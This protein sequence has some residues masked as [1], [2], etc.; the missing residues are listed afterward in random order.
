MIK[1]SKFAEHSIPSDDEKK[2]VSVITVFHKGRRE[3]GLLRN[4]LRL[5]LPLNRKRYVYCR[6]V[7]VY[8]K[9]FP[10]S[11]CNFQIIIEIPENDYETKG[12]KFIQNNLSKLMK[13]ESLADVQFVFGD[14]HIAAHSAIVAAS[15][16]VFAAMFQGEKF[17]EGQTRTV[18]IEDIDSRVFR[19][20]LQFL[21][22]GSSGSSK[23]DPPDE[24]RALFLAADKYQVD[25]LKEICEDCL[26]CQ[27][28]TENV[29]GHLEWAD[30][31]GA[32]KLKDAA[33]TYIVKRRKEVWKLQECEDFNKKYPDLFFLVCKRMVN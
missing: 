14:E 33:V 17:K 24:L 32:E 12:L 31:Y 30:Q 29:L 13:N 1:N 25:A 18:N 11:K 19:K 28:E 5:S 15:S 20:L 26:I 2:S 9:E 10:G 21:Y 6:A 3:E 27:L 22:T 7:D 4:E 8:E 16:P 23:Q